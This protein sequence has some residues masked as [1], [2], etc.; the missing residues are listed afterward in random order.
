MGSNEKKSE[1]NQQ[2]KNAGSNKGLYKK[3]MVLLFILIFVYIISHIITV[4]S[5]KFMHFYIGEENLDRQWAL[6]SIKT[7]EDNILAK[8]QTVNAEPAIKILFSDLEESVLNADREF[9]VMKSFE[10]YEQKLEKL[11]IEKEICLKILHESQKMASEFIQSLPQINEVL[12][13]QFK[14]K[15]KIA[16]T[17]VMDVIGIS[18]LKN[19][20]VQFK[21]KADKIGFGK[22]SKEKKILES[23][24]KELKKNRPN[25]QV[26][27][28]KLSQVAENIRGVQSLFWS[29]PIFLPPGEASADR[30][31]QV[32][33]CVPR[34]LQVL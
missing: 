33:R 2:V 7:L 10:S 27:A 18:R 5:F 8:N 1:K 20:F 6:S 12:K 30:R 22:K 32:S 29:H 14:S 21:E 17:W 23:L 13:V 15:L 31:H 9:D 4:N 25:R 26:I 11:G 34:S 28:A 19:L 16:E 3:T 24:E